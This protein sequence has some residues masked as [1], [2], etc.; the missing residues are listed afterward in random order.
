MS[1]KSYFA[2]VKRSEPTDNMEDILPVS[3]AQAVRKEIEEALSSKKREAYGKLSAET[4]AKIAK[5]TAFSNSIISI[6]ANVHP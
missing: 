5:A 2:P 4:R 1:I 6:V 3:T